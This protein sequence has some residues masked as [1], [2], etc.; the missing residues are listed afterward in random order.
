MSKTQYGRHMQCQHKCFSLE[1]GAEHSEPLGSQTRPLA[2]GASKARLFAVSS[3]EP[4]DMTDFEQNAACE[5]SGL[6]SSI[7]RYCTRGLHS[8]PFLRVS[9]TETRSRLPPSGG[10]SRSLHHIQ[11]ATSVPSDSLTS[12]GEWYA[13]VQS[14]SIP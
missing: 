1:S 10:N 14:K 2:F 3:G 8:L 9:N 12:A 5:L 4:C 13:C 7:N 6:L 11:K